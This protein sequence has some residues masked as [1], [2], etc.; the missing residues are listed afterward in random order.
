MPNSP[1]CED[2]RSVIRPREESKNTPQ[3][4][5]VKKFK[6]TVNMST[7]KRSN[8]DQELL[9]AIASLQANLSKAVDE[10]RSFRQSVEESIKK[11]GAKIEAESK[12]IKD[13]LHLE[14]AQVKNQID[15]I[16]NKILD[17]EQSMTRELV[18]LKSR[19]EKVEEATNLSEYHQDL[20]VIVTGLRYEE[21]ENVKEKAERLVE[22]G[23]G[24]DI[25]VVRAM[26]TPFKANKPGI[27]KIQLSKKED[28]IRVLRNKGKLQEKDQYNRV[29]VR[30]SLSHAEHMAQ[31]NT[32]TI[33]KELGLDSKYRMAGSG[34]L[35]QRES[36]E[37]SNV[38]QGRD[39]DEGVGH[40]G[41]QGYGR[42]R[43]G[44]GGRTG[45]WRGG[46]PYNQRGRPH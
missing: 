1:V 32:Q 28:K 13:E 20:T 45:G 17:V 33:L 46:P 9:D 34:R 11:L 6:E 25:G 19:V 39:L 27:V 8:T 41:G 15:A 29:F 10:Q 35:V 12:D 42:G 3:K 38:D 37:E 30:S 16:E 40:G 44:R 23:M 36:R 22:E 5:A 2:R 31:I 7:V 24:L 21:N 43:G 4:P 14:V 26:R 18:T